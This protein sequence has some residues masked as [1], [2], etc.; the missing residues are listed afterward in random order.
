MSCL[1][2]VFFISD[3]ERAS[4]LFELQF[5]NFWPPIRELVGLMNFS[6]RES[7]HWLIL[8]LLPWWHL[9]LWLDSAD[10]M[11]CGFPVIFFLHSEWR[12]PELMTKRQALWCSSDN[13]TRE[14]RGKVRVMILVDRPVLNLFKVFPSYFFSWEE[15]IYFWR[16]DTSIILVGLLT[17][18]QTHPFRVFVLA[19]EVVCHSCR[20]KIFFQLQSKYISGSPGGLLSNPT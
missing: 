18:I 1:Q 13:M 19:I 3:P 14:K 12:S 7:Q 9:G 8:V 20:L 15:L 2:K 4:K 10:H 6:W 17:I 11:F 16:K 5:Y